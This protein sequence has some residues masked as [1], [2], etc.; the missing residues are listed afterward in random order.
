MKLIRAAFLLFGL[1]LS[2][3]NSKA[4]GV[5]IILTSGSD[6]QSVCVNSPIVNIVYTLGSG[7][8][9]T[10]SGLPTGVAGLQA[11]TLFTISGTPTI[12]GKFDYEVITTGVCTGA[13]SAKGT[14]TSSAVPP[15]PT[16]VSPQSFCQITSPTV[17][18]L[19]ATGS[20]IRWY[21]VPSGGI[22]LSPADPLSSGYY[23]ASQTVDGCESTSRA[24]VLVAVNDSPAPTSISPQT[25]C[26]IN[27]PTL[28]NIFIVGS[29][30]KWYS[31]PV[32]GTALPSSTPLSSATY[33]ASQTTGSCESST[34]VAVV[35]VVNDPPAPTGST[36]QNFCVADNPT[37]ASLTAAGSSIKWYLF[38][39]GGT[40]LSTSTPLSTGTYYASQTVGGCESA[41]RLAVSV[42]VA[43]PTAPTGTSPQ[44]FCLINSPT[45]ADLVAVGTNIKWYLTANGGTALASTTS[46]STRTYYASQTYGSCEST[47]RLAVSVII[48]NP[49]AP[50]GTSPQNFCAIDNPTVANLAATGSGILWYTVST[51]GTPLA[52]TTALSNRTYYASQTV[53]GCES[54]SRLAVVVTIS[55]PA[56]PTASSPQIFCAINNPTVANLT[57][58]GVG[59]RWYTVSTG[60]TALATSTPLATGVYYASQT[61]SGC[62]SVSRVAVVVTVN[63]PTP[64]TGSS[65][66]NFCAVNNPTV[67]NLSATGTGIKWY[68]TPTG[69]AALVSTTP[70]V[71]GNYY[72]SQTVSGCE[73]TSRLTVNVV[74]NNPSA[75]T[76]NATQAFCS[77]TNPTVANLTATGTG[78]LWYLT[79]TGGTPLAPATALATGNYY[80]SQT[81][82]G[83]ESTTR[84]AVAVTVNQTPAANAGTGGSVCGLTFT[85]GA[86]PVTAGTGTWSQTSGPG[87]SVFTPNASTPNATV[88]VTAYG[89]YVFTWTV[90]NNNCSNTSTVTVIFYQV[91]VANAGTGGTEC[92]LNF[93]LNAVP[94]VGL[95]VWSLVTG[96]GTAAFTPSANLAAATVTVS[97][98]GAYTFRWTETNG[99]C[100]SSSVVTVN[101][102]QLPVANAGPSGDACGLSH[103]LNAVPS[104]GVGTWTMTAGTGTASFV[105]DANSPTATVT[106]SEYGPK[107]FTWTEMNGICT[108]SSMITVNFYQQPTANAGTGGNNCG[109]VFNLNAVPSLGTGTWTRESGPG[110][111]NFSPNANTPTAAVTVTAYGTYVFRWT[112]MNGTCSSSA[113]ISV[114]FIQQPSADAGKGGNECDLNFVL[115]AVPGPGI[116]T[117]SKVNGPGNVTFTPNANTYNATVTVTQFGS[118]DFAWTEVNSQC[119]SSDIIRVTFH[120]LPPVSA[121]ADVLLC[122][123]SNVQLNASGTG[124]FSWAPAGSL[125]NPFIP[126]PVASPASTTAYT[127]TLTDQWG[128]KNT[129]QMNVEVREQPVADAGPDQILEFRFDTHFAAGTLGPNQTGEWSIL[130]GKGD[131]SDKNNPSSLVSNLGIDNNSFVWRVSNG[132]CPEATDTVNIV[133]HNLIIPT[134]ITPNLDGNNDYFVIKGIET[135]GTTSLTIFN[136]W[137]GKVYSSDNYDNSWDGTDDNKN[138]LPEDTYFYIL[139]AKNGMAF[140]GY[141]VIRR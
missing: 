135:L 110:N 89:T 43:N 62:E 139:K 35:V 121:G 120:D 8:T 84:L 4:Q 60:G 55:N 11:G 92:D 29:N 5:C 133:V 28:A 103:A 116:G 102:Y 114:T 47:S 63:N 117:W 3:N 18:N 27:N 85:L 36:T 125:N 75:P 132:A 106:V 81:I 30:I 127:V 24:T 128:C 90:V 26:Q 38:P 21:L 141:V 56:A 104:A 53:S 48:N 134:L 42:T 78:I 68:T 64:P 93:V 52:T 7:V 119:T 31:T 14:I 32:G 45:V 99:P 123:G 57:A 54:T 100:I 44:T 9:A 39:T 40:A 65:P 13:A 118:Y 74:V 17:S 95:G 1:I 73:S 140:K 61:V 109:Y 51:G 67:A 83:C 122:K 101:F 124:T 94:S 108:S 16:A 15:L 126:N 91:P 72:A 22:P 77:I 129:D 112:E 96:P 71:T 58:T 10:V 86:T 137:G 59:I 130:E 34:R 69:G 82:G 138:Q 66:Q 20:N 19:A 113:T 70:L 105:P 97:A 80:A 76:G 87:T 88:T 49:S 50:T 111:A 23:Y 37:V 46:L 131:I 41:L 79:S 115:N 12:T 25:F 2:V 33:Y 6:N 136:R 107:V 98:Y